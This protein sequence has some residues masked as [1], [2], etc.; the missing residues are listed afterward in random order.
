FL[1]MV[2]NSDLPNAIEML[3]S[4]AAE[5]LFSLLQKEYDYVIV[6]LAPLVADVDVHVTSR[7]IDSYL[8]VI[9]WGTTKID[10][11]KNALRH[12]PSLQNHLVGAVLNKVDMAM[13]RRYDKY[14]ANYYYNRDSYAKKAS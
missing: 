2:P 5:I 3:A 7:I 11:V 6:D 9:E 14:G 8:L 10:L 1:P 13:V 12:A 4:D